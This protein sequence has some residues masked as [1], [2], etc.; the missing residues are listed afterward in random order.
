M[1]SKNVYKS[2]SNVAVRSDRV[3][4]GDCLHLYM[5][6]YIIRGLDF[7]HVE[8]KTVIGRTG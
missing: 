3:E 7:W 1:F 2:V 6:I 5:R 8:K 4:K